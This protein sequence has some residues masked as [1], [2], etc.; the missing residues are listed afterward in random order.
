MSES[1]LKMTRSRVQLLAIIAIFI[2]PMV[3]AKIVW[4]YFGEHGVNTTVNHGSLISPAKPLM[5]M[6]LVDAQHNALPADLLKGHWTYVMFAEN[7][8]DPACEQQ[9]YVTRQTRVSVNKD[10]QRVQR[11][12]VLGFEPEQAWLEKLQQEHP[13]LI[14]AVLT[15]PIWTAFQVQ[16]QQD[17]EAIGGMPFFLVDPLGNLMMGYDELA[18]P[19]GILS[20]LRKLLKIS[21]IG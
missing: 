3:L 15:R 8:C 9:L 11:L 4:E 5:D 1:V 13:E 18:T 2:I 20:D 21:Q 19:K 6:V 16:F 12:L 14:V 7:S 17:I 10:M